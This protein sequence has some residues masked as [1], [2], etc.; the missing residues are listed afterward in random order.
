MKKSIVL[1]IALAATCSLSLFAQSVAPEEGVGF[2]PDGSE[3]S[4]PAEAK[5]IDDLRFKLTKKVVRG[6]VKS[7]TDSTALAGAGVVY[8][9]DTIRTANDGS[10]VLTLPFDQEKISL[11]VFPKEKESGRPDFGTKT[12]EFSAD[13]LTIYLA[14]SW[15]WSEELHDI[16]QQH[17]YEEYQANTDQCHPQHL[18]PVPRRS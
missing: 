5:G 4:L 15:N 7:E 10:F 11:T 1:L 3:A 2:P 17:Q 9:Q 13:N 6:V 14:A 16:D 12:A 18:G 8:G